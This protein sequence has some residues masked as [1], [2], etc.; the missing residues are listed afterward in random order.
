MVK[1]FTT[2]ET[3]LTVR[4]DDIDMN[5]HVHFSRYLDYVLAARYDQMGR[6]YKMSMNEFIALGLGWVVKSCSIEYKRPLMLGEKML[7]RTSIADVKTTEARVRFEILKKDSGKI[8]AEGYF[9]YTLVN[10]K[11]GR[12]EK[13]PPDV[14]EKYSI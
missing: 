2:F 8:S 13:I 11:T 3:E 14:I 6:C 9:D 1:T 7:V 12:A 10:L 5:N 4:P